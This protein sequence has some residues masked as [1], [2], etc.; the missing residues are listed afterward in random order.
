MHWKGYRGAVGYDAYSEKFN[1]AKVLS[2]RYDCVIAQDV[3]EHVAEPFVLMRELGALSAPVDRFFVDVLVMADDPA[4]RS[5]RLALLTSLRRTIL[6]I[7]DI[8][9]IAPD[10]T[11]QA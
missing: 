2:E 5:A 9:E 7:A 1:D 3:I 6:N 8:A 10:E 4:V 11:K